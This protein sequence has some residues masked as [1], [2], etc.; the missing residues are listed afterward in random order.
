[1]K[2]LQS[3]LIDLSGLHFD[4]AF[5]LHSDSSCTSSVQ[6]IKLKEM[7]ASKLYSFNIIESNIL[8]ALQTENSSCSVKTEDT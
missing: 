7:N 8:I 4:L 6:S 3:S 1:M 5:F 2:Q